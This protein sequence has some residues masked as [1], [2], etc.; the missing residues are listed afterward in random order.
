MCSDSLHLW[1]MSSPPTR[2]DSDI[3]EAARTHGELVNRSAAQ[4]LAHWA[5]IGRQ[6]ELAP[7]TSVGDVVRVLAGKAD[8]D[9][10]AGPD[11]AVVR[12]AWAERIERQAASL[13]LAAVF[14]AQGRK[15]ASSATPDG[16]AVIRRELTAAGRPRRKQP[17]VE[18]TGTREV[19]KLGL[20][21]VAA[22]A[23]TGRS[24]NKLVVTSVTERV[25]IGPK[26]GK[27]EAAPRATARRSGMTKPEPSKKAAS[28]AKRRAT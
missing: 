6:L 25:R 7:S 23:A 15:V 19:Q 28:T 4:Q 2:I 24:K 20:G 18:I 26:P 9:D 10:L 11:Q 12:A 22:P 13:E 8:Y 21:A 16:Q 17:S 1:A 5:R 3:Y 27:L 14:A